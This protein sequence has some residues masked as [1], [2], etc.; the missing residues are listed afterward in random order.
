MSPVPGIVTDVFGELGETGKQTARQAVKL[1]GNLF[2][3]GGKQVKGAPA[4]NSSDD[5]Q[6]TSQQELE[7]KKKRDQEKSRARYRQILD[8]MQRYRQN[9]A[10]ETPAYIAGKPGAPKDREEEVDLWQE[11][12]DEEEK[13]K[14]R[15]VVKLP[16]QGGTKGTGERLKGVSG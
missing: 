13:E 3:T 8:E 6:L 9:Q 15:Q 4:S 14:K 2:E 1:P 5:K 12:K 11:Q 10:K 16:G 7:L